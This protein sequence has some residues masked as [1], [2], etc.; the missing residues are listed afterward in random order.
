MD[1]KKLLPKIYEFC[2]KNPDKKPISLIDQ[3]IEDA[4]K[5]ETKWKSGTI[6]WAADDD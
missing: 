1:E 3:M 6:P 5:I 2:T 4:D